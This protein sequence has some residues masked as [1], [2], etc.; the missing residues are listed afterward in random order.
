M[1][2]WFN[3]PFLLNEC[4]LRLLNVLTYFMIVSYRIIQRV[5]RDHPLYSL[6]CFRITKME[7]DAR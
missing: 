3:F 4:L 2:T 1:I 6:S 7:E 5:L